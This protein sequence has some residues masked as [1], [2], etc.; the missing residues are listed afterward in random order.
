MMNKEVPAT[1]LLVI[2]IVICESIDR[3]FVITFDITTSC[4]FE[5][6][7]THVSEVGI[8]IRHVSRTMTRRWNDYEHLPVAARTLVVNSSRK[9]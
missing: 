2:F 7:V 3:T 4:V 5:L 6:N 8:K 9:I 1:H